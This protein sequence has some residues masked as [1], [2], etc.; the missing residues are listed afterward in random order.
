MT[1]PESH[2]KDLASRSTRRLAESRDVTPLL[3]ELG[4]QAEGGL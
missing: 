2:L 4:L 3:A 1:G